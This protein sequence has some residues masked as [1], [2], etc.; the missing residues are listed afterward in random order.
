MLKHHMPHIICVCTKRI[1]SSFTL[2]QNSFKFLSFFLSRLSSLI[3]TSIIVEKARKVAHMMRTTVI[4]TFI[5]SFTR[6]QKNIF[7]DMLLCMKNCK[8][9]KKGTH[10]FNMAQKMKV[11]VVS[12]ID[13][14]FLQN[15]KIIFHHQ[16]L[17]F[18]KCKVRR[19]RAKRFEQETK[20]FV[21]FSASVIHF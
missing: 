8:Q 13:N 10:K 12:N 1:S 15:E 4:K 18:P 14:P 6:I 11:K 19:R 17:F 3:H 2:Q 9:K 21:W 5:S 16:I 20:L 7:Y